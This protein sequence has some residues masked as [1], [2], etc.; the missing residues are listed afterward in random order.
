MSPGRLGPHAFAAWS[1]GVASQSLLK[2]LLFDL[3]PYDP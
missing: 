1:A 3:T 2:A